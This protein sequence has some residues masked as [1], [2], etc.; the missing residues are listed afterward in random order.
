MRLTDELYYRCSIATEF[1]TK[2][3][4]DNKLINYG[5]ATKDNYSILNHLHV[6]SLLHSCSSLLGNSNLAVLA[7]RLFDTILDMSFMHED[8]QCIIYDDQSWTVW[9]ALASIILFKKNQNDEGIKFL[10][11]VSRCIQENGIYLRYNPATTPQ[12]M[13]Q[14]PSIFDGIILI[15]FIAAYENT[16]QKEHLEIAF[17]IALHIIKRK[18]QYDQYHVW[19]LRLLSQ[20]NDNQY[21]QRHCDKIIKSMTVISASNTTSIM[22]GV[23]QQAF[24]ANEIFSEDFMEHQMSL[25]IDEK[26]SFNMNLERFKGAFVHS[27]TQHAIQVDYLIHN[28]LSFVVYLAIQ[29][30]SR[31]LTNVI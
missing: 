19:G 26:H 5:K 20:V 27:K 21:Y 24:L 6:V 30:K 16:K 7:D 3:I 13:S 4:S 11:C 8:I 15:A 2:S 28:V 31:I 23:F 12:L 18:P 9:N 29:N 14:K 17:K 10:K 22:A 25:Q 1:I